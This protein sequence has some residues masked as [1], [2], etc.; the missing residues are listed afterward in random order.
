MRHFFTFEEIWRIFGKKHSIWRQISVKN[1]FNLDIFMH[2]GINKIT[3][4]QYSKVYKLYIH[5]Y[6]K[7]HPPQ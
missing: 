6:S 3:V 4:K 1:R 7:V 5:K 2:F